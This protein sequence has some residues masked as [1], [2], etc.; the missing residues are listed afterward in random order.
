MAEYIDRQAA[1]DAQ[2]R[3]M[4]DHPLSGYDDEVLLIQALRDIQP[5]DVVEVVRCKDCKFNPLK[6]VVGCPMANLAYDGNRWCWR[7]EQDD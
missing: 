1:I 6:N 7:G 4:S 2:E 3:I 5:A